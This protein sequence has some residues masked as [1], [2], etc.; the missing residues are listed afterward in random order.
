MRRSLVAATAASV[1]LLTAACG[2]SSDAGSGS[3]GGD[4]TLTL[5]TITPPSSFAVGEMAQSG[6]EDHYYQ[7][8]YDTL[9]RLDDDGEPAANLVTE[10]S[11]DETNTRL[12]LTLRDDVTV[13][14]LLTH[15]SGIADYAEED[16]LTVPAASIPELRSSEPEGSEPPSSTPDP[17]PGG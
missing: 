12:S 5:A 7:A 3:A 9:L 15:T 1:L 10:W 17:V 2:G 14:H 16:E 8:V 4:S 13:H 6:P 11:F